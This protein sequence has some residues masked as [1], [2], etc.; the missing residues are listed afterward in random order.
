MPGGLVHIAAGLMSAFVV[1]MI[2]FKW[3]YSY[4]IFIGN[5]LP[6]ALRHGLTAIKQGTIHLF[7][8]ERD[9]FYRSLSVFTSDSGNWL[10]IGFFVL[11]VGLFLFHYH[12]IKKKKME[13]YSELYVFLLVG[14]LTHLVM[15]GLIAEKGIWY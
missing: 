7:S 8:V 9:G 3:E 6:D 10:S 4:A 14:I 13:E 12:Y 2:H 15:D 5:L 1:H 11:A